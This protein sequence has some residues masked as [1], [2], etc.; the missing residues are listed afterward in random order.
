YFISTRT[1]DGITQLLDALAARIKTM[2]ADNHAAPLTRERHREALTHC[3]NH[4]TRAITAYNASKP[5]EL[6]GEDIRLATRAL[7]RI[8]GAVDVDDILDIIFREF[9]IGK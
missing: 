3:Q 2:L 1:G 9:C 8:T 7:A 4:L 5:P 6:V